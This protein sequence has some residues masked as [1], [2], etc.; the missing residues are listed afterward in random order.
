MILPRGE[1]HRITNPGPEPAR[2]LVFC[3]PAGFENFVREVSDPAAATD[4][5]A[6][7]VTPAVGQRMSEAAPRHGIT[8]MRD[9]GSAA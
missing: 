3:T 9:F 7:P 4:E 8:L 2:S 5:T 6:P 1:P